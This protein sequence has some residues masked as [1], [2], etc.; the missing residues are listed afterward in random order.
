M[1]LADGGAL[2]RYEIFS[3]VAKLSLV[4]A[5][6]FFGMRWMINQIDPITKT[7]KK[8]QEKV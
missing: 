6:G 2:S 5:F 8:T 7:R 1:S 3:L 4:T